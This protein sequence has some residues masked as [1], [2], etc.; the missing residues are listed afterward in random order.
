[1]QLNSQLRD[2]LAPAFN[3]C[4]GF[5]APCTEMR[6]RPKDGHVPRG[7]LGAYGDISEVE[8]ILVVAEPGD[9]Q[10]GERH[11]GI[12]SAEAIAA[13]CFGTGRDLFHRNVRRILELCWPG[14]D[15]QTQM[16]KVWITESVLCSALLEGGSVK[17]ITERECGTRYLLPQLALLS[18]ALVVALGSKAQ[19]RLAKLGVSNVLPAYSVAPPGCNRREALESWKQIPIELA[20]R[21]RRQ[22]A[23]KT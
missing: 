7:F 16:R 4:S 17:R 12:E 19:S 11:T 15:F 2:I 3:P 1:M 6:W 14:S 20:K 8:L 5:K 22:L 13:E 9:P 23:A 21:R 10:P 18:N